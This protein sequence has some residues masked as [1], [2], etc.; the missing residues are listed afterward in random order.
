M[1]DLRRHQ[2]FKKSRKVHSEPEANSPSQWMVLFIMYT[3]FVSHPMNIL[4]NL[5]IDVCHTVG[6]QYY[7]VN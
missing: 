4:S 5:F 3:I 7:A 2:I 6:I 1:G